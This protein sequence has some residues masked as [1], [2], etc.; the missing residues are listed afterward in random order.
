MRNMDLRD[1][2][3]VVEEIMRKLTA[4]LLRMYLP[5]IPWNDWASVSLGLAGWGAPFRG[6]AEAAFVTS[7]ISASTSWSEGTITG[8]ESVCAGR[9]AVT[10]PGSSDPAV[11]CCTKPGAG[12]LVSGVFAAVLPGVAPVVFPVV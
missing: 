12:V 7:A 6:I 4:R 5:M 1:G 2:Y 8:V 11:F 3:H 10:G 9:P